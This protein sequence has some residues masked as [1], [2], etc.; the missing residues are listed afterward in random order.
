KSPGTKIHLAG[1]MRWALESGSG[2]Y[3]CYCSGDK[4]IVGIKADGSMDS[5]LDLLTV[6]VDSSNLNGF[7]AGPD[8]AFFVTMYSYNGGGSQIVRVY[9]SGEI[10]EKTVVT[11]GCFSADWSLRA[12]VADFNKHSE[13]Y[14]IYVNSYSDLKD[15]SQMETDL[16]NFNNE[17]LA[18]K[19]PDLLLINSS[20]PYESY[21]AKGM[22]TDM[23][24][25]IDTDPDLDKD[26]FLPNILKAYES[27]DGKLYRLC[28]SFRANTY[29]VKPPLGDGYLTLKDAVAAGQTTGAK[30]DSYMDRTEMLATAL[31]YSDF[32]D[33]AHKTC[34]FDNA[35]FKALLELSKDYP[36]E[37]DFEK[38]ISEDFS[39]YA[40]YENAF[41]EDKSLVREVNITD[42]E[43]LTWGRA[44]LG[45]EY[46]FTNFPTDRPATK[47][48]LDSSTVFS[49]SDTSSNKDG[50]WA[51]VKYSI[52]NYIEERPV[53]Y[54]DADS[55]YVES[56]D[57]KYVTKTG[58]QPVLKSQFDLLSSHACDPNYEYDT[59]GTRKEADIVTYTSAGQVK[60]P[61]LTQEELKKYTDVLT[62]AD[63]I[64]YIDKDIMNIV[65]DEASSYYA[66]T[67]S[68]DETASL[69]QSRVSL[70]MSEH[71]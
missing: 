13:E 15:D 25:I 29:A 18:G 17:L 1:G 20:M 39:F 68:L 62:S 8:G 55:N 34:D 57:K 53:Y 24:S 21:A 61:P 19:V 66:G 9:P 22:F 64:D 7:A 45:N 32:I 10:K 51:F 48:T 71:Y 11:L 69:I 40:N 44:S 47:A 67:K 3:I 43:S 49:I 26:S 36:D 65:T 37:I 27:P 23:Y 50:A 41:I 33:Y 60:L 31:S 6:G 14:T 16:T 5:V 54:Y 70:Y 59:D 2:D 46:V 52:L 35:E 28:T 30:I 42:Y 56:G 63:R 12:L 58:D 38:M 4:G